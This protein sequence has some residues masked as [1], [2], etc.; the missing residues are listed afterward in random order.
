MI[1]VLI[2]DDSAVMRA[3]LSR[4]VS[5]QPDMEV[6]AVATDP[7]VAIEQIRLKSPDVMTL[8]VEMPR[9]NGLD[10]LRKV[11]AVRPLPVIM[12]SSL[13]RQGADTTMQ[14]LELG[15]VDFVQKPADL[16]QFEASVN[17]IAEKIR[18]ANSAQVVRRR[19]RAAAAQRRRW[20]RCGRLFRRPPRTV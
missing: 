18:A 12:I 4:V 11:M 17:D 20:R 6:V 5:A 8:D 1:R 13:T 7:M 9:M 10:F 14:A 2:V 3:F 16:S 15:A 19:P